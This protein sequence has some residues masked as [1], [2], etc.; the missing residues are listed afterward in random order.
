MTTTRF[1]P[2]TVEGVTA[3]PGGGVT[4]PDGFRAAGVA[5]GLKQ[6]EYDTW[7]VL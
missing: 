7:Y 1:G 2:T 3:L 5:A 4:T 6:H